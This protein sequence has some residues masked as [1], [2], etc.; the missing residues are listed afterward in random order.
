[1]CGIARRFNRNRIK[2]QALGQKPV[3]DQRIKRGQHKRAD[4]GK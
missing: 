2:V 3:S 1:M 4:I